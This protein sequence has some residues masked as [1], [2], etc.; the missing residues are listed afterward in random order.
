LLLDRG[1]DVDAV[2]RRWKGLDE[3]TDSPCIEEIC[4]EIHRLFEDEGIS[5]SPRRRPGLA[6]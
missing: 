2:A 3:P 6:E 5:R 4:F 1:G